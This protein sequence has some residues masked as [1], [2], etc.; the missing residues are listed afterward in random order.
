MTE[1]GL[2]ESREEP[3]NEPEIGNARRKY[4]VTTY[5]ERIFKAQE[6]ALRF[7]NI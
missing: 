5:G 1:K 7:L 3:R 4:K 6:L 2:V